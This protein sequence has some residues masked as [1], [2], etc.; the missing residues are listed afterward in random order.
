MLANIRR[1][2]GGCQR[3]PQAPPAAFS[4]RA[5]KSGIRSDCHISIGPGVSGAGRSGFIPPFRRFACL[6][7]SQITSVTMRD[8]RTQRGAIPSMGRGGSRFSG[9][10]RRIVPADA[11]LGALSRRRGS[12]HRCDPPH[13]GFDLAAIAGI[14]VVRSQNLVQALVPVQARVGQA[15]AHRVDACGGGGKLCAA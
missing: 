15:I 13:H 10:I 9:A 1:V 2:A 8:H 14:G 5:G 12:L 11:A 6:R 4:W 3:Y 7:P